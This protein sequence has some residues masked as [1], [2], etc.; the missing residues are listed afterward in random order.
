MAYGREMFLLFRQ[1]HI[2]GV[3]T[4]SESITTI[5]RPKE[6]LRVSKESQPN[7][8]NSPPSSVQST[9]PAASQHSCAEPPWDGS[10]GPRLSE[11]SQVVIGLSQECCHFMLPMHQGIM[12]HSD[13]TYCQFKSKTIHSISVLMNPCKSQVQMSNMSILNLINLFKGNCWFLF[14]LH[15]CV[16]SHGLQDT[17]LDSRGIR[18]EALHI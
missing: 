13:I 1:E 16:R 17:P 15:D 8:T 18:N 12:M 5:P 10:K 6:I 7:Q 11:S 3:L 4:P 2:S 14:A 9:C